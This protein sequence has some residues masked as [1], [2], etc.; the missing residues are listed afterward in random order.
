MSDIDFDELDKAVNNLMSNVDTRKRNEGLG[1]PEVK[2]VTLDGEPEAP[3]P[4]EVAAL[5]A[6]K[7]STEVIVPSAPIA[8]APASTPA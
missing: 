8:P 6:H 1:D 5:A 7:P 3:L 2:T 4:T